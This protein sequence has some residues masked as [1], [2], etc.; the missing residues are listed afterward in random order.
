MNNIT[1]NTTQ[2]LI[3]AF[4]KIK[5]LHRTEGPIYDLKHSEIFVLFCIK[6]SKN[7]DSE[8][9]KISEISTYMKVTNPT[10]T[11]VI[12]GLEQKGYVKRCV[13]KEDKRVVRISLTSKGEE[14]TT[15]AGNNLTNFFEG[16]TGYLGE[17]KSLMLTELIN[18]V[19]KYFDENKK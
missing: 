4:I 16:L 11:Q 5:K 2:K 12:N 8:G 7:S 19:Y 14:A 13:D 3:E 10:T 1:N 6:K 15:K 9:L 17:E 18:D